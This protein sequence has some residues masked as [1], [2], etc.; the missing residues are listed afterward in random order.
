LRC[1]AQNGTVP[2]P[3]RVRAGLQAADHGQHGVIPVEDHR[4]RTLRRFAAFLLTLLL[5]MSAWAQSAG[6]FAVPSGDQSKALFLDPLFGALTGSGGSSTFG[7]LIQSFNSAAMIIGGLIVAYT[8]VAGTMATAHDGE[9]L[10]KQWSSLWVPIRTVI[11]TAFVMPIL[12][13]G[14]CVAQAIVIWCALQ[15]VGLAD[16]MTSTF[17]STALTANVAPMNQN[18]QSVR[19]FLGQVL[20][21]LTCSEVVAV[22]THWMSVDQVKTP[23]TWSGAEAYATVFGTP[24]PA[25]PS[26]TSA[27][28]ANGGTTYLFSPAKDDPTVGACGSVVLSPAV[29][30]AAAPTQAAGSGAASL[31]DFSAINSAVVSAQQSQM[32]ADV[33]ALDATAKQIAQSN[34][35]MASL[36]STVNGQMATMSQAWLTATNQAAQNASGAATND[37][38][39]SAIEND[40]WLYLGAWYMSVARAQQAMNETVSSV[41]T[42]STPTFS[43]QSNSD[44]HW[45]SSLFSSTGDTDALTATGVDWSGDDAALVR[46]A[47]RLVSAAPSADGAPDLAAKNA[48]PTSALDRALAWAIGSS[49]SWDVMSGT[50]D[51]KQNPVISA[52]AL[53]AKLLNVSAVGSS[54]TLVAGAA[55]NLEVLGVGS[56]GTGTAL[57]DTLKPLWLGMAILGGVLSFYIPMLPLLLWLGAAIGW[58]ALLIEGV[59]AAPLWMCAHLLPTGEGIA[60]A[61]KRGYLM[62]LGLTL[63]PPLMVLGFAAATAIMI[64]VGT[65]LN[66]VFLGAFLSSI[67]PSLFGVLSFF[68]GIAMYTLLL[69]HLVRRVF[70]L[71]HEV[72]DH[73]LGWID[74]HVGERHGAHANA[75]TGAIGGA[76]AAGV[77][78]RALEGSS[79]ILGTFSGGGGGSA[80]PDSR[81]E[82]ANGADT[83]RKTAPP[84]ATDAAVA[85]V[86]PGSIEAARDAHSAEPDKPDDAVM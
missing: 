79:R 45:W 40:G 76:V 78:V 23:G 31:F 77:G 17:M 43:V 51:A 6:P 59:V 22:H 38:L 33:T 4:M 73:A 64:P 46:D 11:G 10:G 1:A 27:P 24:P 54:A 69:Q 25:S 2:M 58:L 48:A 56:P 12:P 29:T 19:G 68:G 9:M 47:Q 34:V 39:T 3:V 36:Q 57:V 53:G 81:G 28:N 74:A 13:G 32:A 20:V 30:A 37:A 66:S 7:A 35:S 14:F 61:G 86:S 42:V 49:T 16:K 80:P 15:G 75:L 72:P 26:A 63:R 21:D 8:L 60:G 82:T 65:L 70:A 41:P 85:D 55:L 50:G 84:T 62:L 5:P 18:D 71:I 67:H 52:E 44:Q 83:E